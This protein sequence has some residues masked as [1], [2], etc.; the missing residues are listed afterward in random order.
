MA[1]NF[2]SACRLPCTIRDSGLYNP[3]FSSG[4]GVELS[5][6]RL[7]WMPMLASTIFC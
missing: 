2:I 4:V 3:A 7:R 6:G 5:H 1:S